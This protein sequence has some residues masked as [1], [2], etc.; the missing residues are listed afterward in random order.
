VNQSTEVFGAVRNL[1]NTD[2]AERADFAFG[3]DRYFPGEDRAFS[4]GVRLIR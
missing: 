1:T 4:L 3:N 2:Y